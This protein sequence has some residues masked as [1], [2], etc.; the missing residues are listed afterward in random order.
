[1]QAA[2]QA[3]P[4][5]ECVTVNTPFGTLGGV[6]TSD[7]HSQIPAM[8]DGPAARLLVAGTPISCSTDVGEATIAA[9]TFAAACLAV[10]LDAPTR[11][12]YHSQLLAAYRALTVRGV[13]DVQ[14][15]P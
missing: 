2:Q 13:A 3:R 8:Y 4:W 5:H 1:M 11:A 7:L 15:Q 14:T 6:R 10:G 12:L 9:L